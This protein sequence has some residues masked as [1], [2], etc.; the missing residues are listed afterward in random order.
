MIGD[1]PTPAGLLWLYLGAVPVL[2]CVVMLLANPRRIV[3]STLFGFIASLWVGYHLTPLLAIR[4]GGWSSFLLRAEHVET[5]IAYATLA[6]LAFLLGY[7]PL[8]RG[9]PSL[10]TR[11]FAGIDAFLPSTALVVALTILTF[12]SFLLSI[13]GPGQLWQADYGRG[14][15]QFDAMTA[16]RMIEGYAITATSVLSFATALLAGMLLAR[17]FVSPLGWIGIAVALLQGMHGF[18]RTA[19]FPLI[20]LAILLIVRRGM[21]AVTPAILV[22]LLALWLGW[23]GFTMRSVNPGIGTFLA[24]LGSPA[25]GLDA[26]AVGT[27]SETFDPAMNP[28]NAL[29]PWTT[30]AMTRDLDRP[31]LGQGFLD[32]LKIL[33]PVPSFLVPWQLRMGD[34]LSVVLGTSGSTGI[35]TPALGELYYALGYSGLLLL[36]PLGSFCAVVDQQFHARKRPRDA[37][38]VVLFLIGF[39]TGLHSGLRAMTRPILYAVLFAYLMSIYDRMKRGSGSRTPL[40]GTQGRVRV[41]LSNSTM[42]V[43]NQSNM[44]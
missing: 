1:W 11:R 5:G 37:I 14:E 8:M 13:G 42:K 40:M 33:Q 36:V 28:L 9:D 29:D 39:G 41:N 27:G 21:W 31:E 17:R 35:T 10:A 38:V 25:A 6:M 16:F 18:S 12:L 15:G 22:L 20:V 3:F 34:S 32:I 44:L 30:R 23:T 43:I 7:L 2:L 26:S 24:A 19:G 4:T